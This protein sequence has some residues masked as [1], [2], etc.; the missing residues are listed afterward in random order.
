MPTRNKA[1]KINMSMNLELPD[2][3]IHYLDNGIPV[4]VI[5]MGTQEVLKLEAIFQ[6]GRPFERKK[7]ASRGVA[8][9][10]KEGNN[11][12][13]AAQLAEE[14][15]FYGSSLSSPFNIDTGNLVLYSLTKHFDYVLPHFADTLKT[16]SFPKEELASFI[17]R[18]QQHLKI[19]LRKNEVLSYRKITEL[20]FGEDHPYGYNSF[21][22]TYAA[23]H[24]DDLVEHHERLFTQD[25]CRLILSGKVN[26]HVLQQINHYLG[27]EWR[28]NS[29]IV[30]ELTVVTSEP[31]TVFEHLPESLQASIRIGNRL[32]NRNHPDSHGLSVLN[33]LLGGYFGSRL[34][35]NIREDKGYTYNISSVVDYM[36]FDG[37]FYVTTEVGN[38]FAALALQEIYN[39]LELLQTDLVDEEE[40]LMVQNYLMGNFLAALDGP[41]NVSE[42]VKTMVS[43]DIP[44]SF[45]REGVQ[46]VREMTAEE[47]KRLAC[48]YLQ[49]DNMWEVIVGAEA[50]SMIQQ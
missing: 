4:H 1:P 40:L 24:R 50:L 39:E 15:D 28:R 10:L 36:H 11:R 35:A 38:E 17:K 12:L 42:V 37:C 46:N 7:L 13:S 5:A 25:N 43:E 48:K 21:P 9:M 20:I 41:F 18:N 14:L 26:D 33:T 3:Q 31:R 2:I 32:F 30:P 22:E 27:K 6:A 16:P 29:L 23:L 49:R 47:I 44:F 34:M 8:S 19:D 45:F